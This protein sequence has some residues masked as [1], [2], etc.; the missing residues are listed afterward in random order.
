MN[1]IN[2]YVNKIICGNALEVLKKIPGESINCCVCSPPFWGLRDYGVEPV[3]WDGDKNCKH[4]WGNKTITL[5]HK[6][7]ET[8]PGKESWFKDRGA[9]D[10]KGNCFCL[11]CGAWCGSL[12]LEPTFGLYIKHLCDIF[13]GVKRVLRKDGT[14]W[15]NLGDSY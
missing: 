12:G 9:S 4:S 6:S 7:G 3:I 14:C 13:D 5:K 11:K 2:H 1:Y 8:N 15:I 10:D